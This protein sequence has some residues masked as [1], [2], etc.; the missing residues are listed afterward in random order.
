[1]KNGLIGLVVG[2]LFLLS[3]GLAF[4]STYETTTLIVNVAAEEDCIGDVSLQFSLPDEPGLAFEKTISGLDGYRLVTTCD[5]GQYLVSA[6]LDGG[7]GYYYYAYMEESEIECVA[8]GTKVINILAGSDAFVKGYK[9]LLTITDEA[10]NAPYGNLSSDKILSLY[11]DYFPEQLETEIP[12]G[13]LDEAVP[14][15]EE[16]AE[17]TASSFEEAPSFTASSKVK[18][19]EDTETTGAE[20]VEKKDT[21]GLLLFGILVFAGA[22]AMVV[23]HAIVKKRRG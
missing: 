17:T 1:M 6:Q 14:G 23:I 21:R 20:P 16:V 13:A 7:D 9:D 15:Q 4:A 19:Q 2:V 10:G 3:A 11:E 5:P 8:G 12:Q 18:E 22:F